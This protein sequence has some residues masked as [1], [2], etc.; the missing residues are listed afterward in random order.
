MLHFSGLLILL[1]LIF[2]I[3]KDTKWLIIIDTVYFIINSI[4]D[5]IIQNIYYPVTEKYFRDNKYD[6]DTRGKGYI[7]KKHIYIFSAH[8]TLKLNSI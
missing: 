2:L 5:N 8:G 6:N 7:L 1:E 4:N 3:T